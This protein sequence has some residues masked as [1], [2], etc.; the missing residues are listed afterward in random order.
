[1]AFQIAVSAV[2]GTSPTLDVVIQETMDGTNYYDAYH[3]ERITAAGT[4]FSPVMKLSGIGIRYVR[5]VSGTSPSF[6]MSAVR[7]SRAG[8]SSLMRRLFDRTINPNT[9]G[10]SSAALFTEGTNQPYLVVS[11]GAGGTGGSP[12]FV[13]QGSE[14]GSNWYNINGSTVTVATNSIGHANPLQGHLPK[15]IRASVSTAGGS[16]YTLN[17]ASVKSMGP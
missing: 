13:I 4:Y 5:T 11:L 6:T 16:G 12:S 7:I 3:F 8:N 14:D 10:S 1:V 15:F 9:L 2:S 17:Y